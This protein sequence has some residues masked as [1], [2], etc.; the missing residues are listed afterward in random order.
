MDRMK[1]TLT[2]ETENVRPF[3]GHF[4]RMVTVTCASTSVRVALTLLA[5]NFLY[6]NED[7]RTSHRA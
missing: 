5:P 7:Q 3:L 1:N 2:S 6:N 4:G